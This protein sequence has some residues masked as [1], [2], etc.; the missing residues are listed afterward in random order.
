MAFYVRL[1]DR[2]Q[3][4]VGLFTTSTPYLL[5]ARRL[6]RPTSQAC[7]PNVTARLMAW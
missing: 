2:E 3:L 7:V 5:V 4:Q 6:T 1:A